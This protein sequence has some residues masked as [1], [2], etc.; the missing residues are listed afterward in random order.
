MKGSQFIFIRQRISKLKDSPVEIIQSEE[1]RD[2]IL[3]KNA[4]S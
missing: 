1:E 2:K 4:M 3:K